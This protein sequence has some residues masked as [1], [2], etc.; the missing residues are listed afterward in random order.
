MKKR[1]VVITALG[2]VSS[3]GIGKDEFWQANLEA[4]SGV[5]AIS[6]F[7]ASLFNSRI[8]SAVKNFNPEDYI[9]RDTAKKADR[10]VHL[11][12]AA[13]KLAFDDLSADLTKTDRTRIGV[14]YGS[15]LGGVL[16]HEE[17]ILKGYDKGTHRLHPLCVPRITPNAVASQ[18]AIYFNLLGPNMV[19]SNACASGTNA[20]GEAYRKI[21]Y[22]DA[23]MV[24]TGGAEAPLTEF[25]FGAYDAMRVLSKRNS[26]PQAASRPFDR[27]RDGFVLAEGAATLI[28]EDL[29]HALKR[30]AHIYAEITG[31]FSNSGA[32]HMAIPQPEGRDIGLAMRGVL[33]DARL[34]PKNID[35]INAH[36]TS[37]TLNDKVETKAIKDVFGKAAYKV[38]VSSTK[39]M[40]GH[41]IGAAGAIEAVACC[42]AIETQLVPPTINYQNPDPDCDLDY[43]PGQPRQAKL[44]NVLSNSFGFGSNNACLVFRKFKG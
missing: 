29:K 27:E 15:G 17:Q 24:I 38:P 18:I 5:T 3:V 41:A 9:N 7:D 40:V 32:Y 34:K 35:Y 25:T 23:D 30:R 13:T 42:L 14:I 20:I 21:Q 2:V 10:F 16:F 22:G 36:G 28:L 6:D 43:V 31:Y 26:E 44:K 33:K 37:T 19:I 8:S 12:L 1:R 39:S 4:R 11:G